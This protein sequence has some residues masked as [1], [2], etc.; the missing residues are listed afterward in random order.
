MYPDQTI[1]PLLIASA[2]LPSA[3]ISAKSKWMARGSSNRQL[4]FHFR[5]RGG[6]RRGAG[7]P[8]NG[9]K[10]GVSHLR[11]PTHSRHHPLH[12]TLRLRPGVP[13]LRTSS[14]FAP[15][16]AA[17]AAASDRLGF[18]LVH[19]SVQSN[20]LHLIAEAQDARCL[21]RGV[22]GLTVRVARAV[23]RRLQ[24][25]GRLF[26]DRYHARALKTPRSVRLALRYVLLN[27]RKHARHPQTSR[28]PPSGAGDVPQGFV[29]P[30]SS[31]P[32]FEGF[33]RPPAL[34]FGAAAARAEWAR[35]SGKTEPPI[36]APHSWLLRIGYQRA[37]PFDVDDEPR[38][39]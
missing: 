39:H 30:R 15:V 4:G 11:R 14:L 32:W 28:T 38:A 20:H 13:S 12:V 34:T 35:S 5:T 29:D 7:R 8:L 17:L 25:A 1:G 21:S 36:A 27:A 22:Q 24:R 33:S 26:A 23:N 6:A 37:G 3:K 10:P 9:E 19:F 18:R 16:R 31:A 2:C